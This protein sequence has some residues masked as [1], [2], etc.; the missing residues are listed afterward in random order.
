M[1]RA[2]SL[3][4]GFAVAWLA[5]LGLLSFVVPPDIH[6]DALVALAPMAACAALSVR[7]TAGF[8]V[9]ALVLTV[10]L[11][12]QNG[13]WG[14]GQQWVRLFDAVAVSAA[15]V[16]IATVRSRRE[17]QLNRLTNISQIAQQAVL[18][19]VPA[20]VPG[21]AVA[22]RYES[23]SE[24]AFVGGDLYDCSWTEGYTRFIIGDVRG[25]GIA[26]LGQAARV[27]RSFR[28]AAATK[29]TLPEVVA[30]MDTYLQSFFGPEDFVTAVVVDVTTPD[31]LKIV[32]C[33]HQ[34]ALLVRANGDAEFLDA[35]AGLPLGI[36]HD[37]DPVTIRWAPG[38]RLLLYTDGMSEARDRAGAFFPLRAQAALLR[39]GS[40]EDALD[41]LLERLFGHVP[42]GQ[43][44]DDLAAVLLENVPTSVSG[45]SSGDALTALRDDPRLVP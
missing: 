44:G 33:G 9:A 12:A 6:L 39:E 16:V 27:I 28:Q 36:G 10:W 7:A 23:A 13:A 4:A 24:D 35:P 8:A 41:A 17:R 5:L 25:K 40:L 22:S 11:G 30:D 37:S 29:E 45:R 19:V 31:Q 43:L 20:Q 18:P 26:A 38:D 15:A 42:S 1:E 34:P 14:T 32:S 21:V 2:V 3:S